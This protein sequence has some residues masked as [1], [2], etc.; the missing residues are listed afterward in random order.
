M[1]MYN[2]AKAGRERLEIGTNNGK[3]ETNFQAQSPFSSSEIEA[4]NFKAKFKLNFAQI[5]SFRLGHCACGGEKGTRLTLPDRS[6]KRIF[7]W[8]ADESL[9]ARKTIKC[10]KI[11]ITNEST[12]LMPNRI[13]RV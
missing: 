4:E 3:T 12:F 5:V 7:L 10:H 11:T 8:N 9:E 1:L 13:R 6:R 2:E